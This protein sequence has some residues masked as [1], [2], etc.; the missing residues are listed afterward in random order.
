ML[1]ES[2]Y[3]RFEIAIGNQVGHGIVDRLIFTQ[4]D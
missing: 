1:L 3:R 4:I 2:L